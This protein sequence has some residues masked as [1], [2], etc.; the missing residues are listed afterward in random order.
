MRSKNKYLH[1]FKKTLTIP[2]SNPRTH[3]GMYK[4]AIDF[5]LKFNIPILAAFD[6]EV[7]EAKDDSKK[8]GLKTKYQELKYNNYIIIKHKNNEYSH[9]FH[10]AHKSTKV[11]KGQ[12]VKE[13]QVIATGI[14]I[15]GFTSLP[16]LHFA[17]VRE[18]RTGS[19]RAVKIRWKD[20]NSK[21][22]NIKKLVK[23][24][25]KPEYKEL[26]EFMEQNIQTI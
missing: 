25:I 26:K 15:I 18:R 5:L 23:I 24:I 12:H 21:I 8:G 2:I 17:V 22:R 20:Y 16:H 14:G 11:K 1:P 7:V 3:Q 9:Y 10:L 4:H 19:F 6:G 13:R